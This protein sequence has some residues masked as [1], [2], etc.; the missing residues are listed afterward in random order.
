[1]YESTGACLPTRVV[2]PHQ[3]HADHD[4]DLFDKCACEQSQLFHHQGDSHAFWSL[5]FAFSDLPALVALLPLGVGV[6]LPGVI[7]CKSAHACR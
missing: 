1:M 4:T 2:G 5:S 6:A 3:P 7:L